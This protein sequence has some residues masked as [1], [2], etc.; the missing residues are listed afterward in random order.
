MF[1]LCLQLHCARLCGVDGAV[2]TR[3]ADVLA[4]QEAGQ[5]ISRLQVREH[6]G[7]YR[8]GLL[9]CFVPAFMMARRNLAG[10]P[11]DGH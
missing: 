11:G 3:A 5:P 6:A 1:L 9:P 8:H 7:S 4:L 2:L 10:I